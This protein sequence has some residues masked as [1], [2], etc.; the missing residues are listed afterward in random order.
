MRWKM[1]YN[2]FKKILNEQIFENSKAD[3]VEKVAM[4]PDRY[5]GLFRPTKPKAKILQNLL[6]SNEIK[7]GDALEILF[8]EYFKL[9]NFKILEKKIDDLSLDQLFTNGK[10]IFFVEQ[11]IRDDHDS[12][13]KRGQIENFE[14]KIEVLLNKL[15]IPENS[16][17]AFMYFVDDSLVKNKNYYLEELSKIHR[18]YNVSCTI[19]YGKDFWDSINHSDIWEEVLIYL[20]RWKKE[21]PDMPSINLDENPEKSF[22]EICNLKPIIFRNLFSDE[23]ICEEILPIIFSENKTL[24]LLKNEFLE[25]GKSQTIYK[26]LA[27]KIDT[28][29][30]Q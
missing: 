29:L 11:K 7:M 24:T 18:D 25:R 21:I 3:L 9:L 13:K 20:E 22:E 1:D 27:E 23:R 26:S 28:Y 8:E 2:S 4:N 12:T 19:C 15:K 16:L 17:R 6:Q 14:R 10:I 5:V 30:M